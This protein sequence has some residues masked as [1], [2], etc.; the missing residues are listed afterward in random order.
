M[1]LASF[2]GIRFLPH[3]LGPTQMTTIAELEITDTVKFKALCD[4][5]DDVNLYRLAL[6]QGIT[7]DELEELLEQLERRYREVAD[8]HN[9]VM[10]AN[11]TPHLDTAILF[12]L[13]PVLSGLHVN[14]A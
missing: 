3:K 10:R 8:A 12:Q 5:A 4:T 7:A 1:R 9:R 11:W 2:G 6:E 14:K 13:C